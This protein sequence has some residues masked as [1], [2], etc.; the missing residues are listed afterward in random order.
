MGGAGGRGGAGDVD[1]VVMGRV[2]TWDDGVLEPDGRPHGNV[3]APCAAQ[4]CAQSGKSGGAWRSVGGG[5]D[6]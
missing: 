6:S 4:P 3:N 2:S 1:S 5:C